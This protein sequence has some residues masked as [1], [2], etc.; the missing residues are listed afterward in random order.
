MA[1]YEKILLT[2]YIV[3]WISIF[4]FMIDRVYDRYDMDKVMRVQS[5]LFLLNLTIY[6]WVR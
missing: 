4:L 1:I 5:C 2:Q 3:I 6:L